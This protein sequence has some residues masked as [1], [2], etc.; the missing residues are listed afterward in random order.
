[1]SNTTVLQLGHVLSNMVSGYTAL[2][3]EQTAVELQ[4]GHVLS[5]MVREI[6]VILRALALPGLQL[7]HVLSNM[8]RPSKSGGA[9][10]GSRFNWAMSFQT[11]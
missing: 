9:K 8:V 10:S 2:R 3:A 7:G 6:A 11:W 5:N 1:M 4:L